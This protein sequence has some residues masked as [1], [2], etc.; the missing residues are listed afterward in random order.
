MAQRRPAYKYIEDWELD[1]PELTEEQE[2]VVA[3]ILRSLGKPPKKSRKVSVVEEDYMLVFPS[4][5][6]DDG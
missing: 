3:E 6:S 1:V 2:C 5:G 4:R